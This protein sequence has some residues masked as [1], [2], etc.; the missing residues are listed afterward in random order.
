MRGLPELIVLF[1]G[2]Y[3]LTSIGLKLDPFPAAVLSLSVVT[4]AYYMEAIRGALLGV[5][6]GQWEAARALGLSYPRTI[7]RIV[8]PQAIRILRAPY[9][10]LTTHVVK[11]TTLVS[12]VGVQELFFRADHAIAARGTRSRCTSSP[13]SSTS[14]SIP[15]SSSPEA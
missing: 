8:V 14:R 2:F 12:A 3:Y 5:P 9:M 7:R 4:S 6:R 1:F 15:R 10:S 13:R 11:S